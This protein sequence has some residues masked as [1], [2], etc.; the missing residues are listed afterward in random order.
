MQQGDRYD[1]VFLLLLVTSVFLVSYHFTNTNISDE[2]LYSTEAY[3]LIKEGSLP[4]IYPLLPITTAGWLILFG[5]VRYAFAATSYVSIIL[6]ALLLYRFELSRL[7]NGHESVIITSLFVCNPLTVW[8]LSRNMTEP[9]FALFILGVAYII[10]GTKLTPS[11]SFIAGLL[12]V[13]AYVTRY[14]GIIIFPAA[15]LFLIL[16]KKGIAVTVSYA[17]STMIL[18]GLWV[19]NKLTYGSFLT[20]ESYSLASLQRQSDLGLSIV[21]GVVAK[22]VLG[23]GIL[24]AYSLPFLFVVA[25]RRRVFLKE[26]SL[27]TFV[28]FYWAVHFAYFFAISLALARAASGFGFARYLWPT[29]P[30]VLTLLHVPSEKSWI[31]YSLAALCMILGI[32]EGVYLIGYVDSHTPFVMGWNDFLESLT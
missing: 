22:S 10:F 30:L 5:L 13:L 17:S 15:L 1:I 28:I 2:R 8:L 21:S 29:L 19:F 18:C 31:K 27:L 6:V 12:S 9:L 32:I 3:L 16:K 11:R 25:V 20:S 14:A 7:S 24:F 23:I 4:K 26:R